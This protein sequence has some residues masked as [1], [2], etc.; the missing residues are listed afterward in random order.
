MDGRD[1]A[2]YRAACE[3]DGK[4]FDAHHGEPSDIFN[5]MIQSC[6]EQARCM[7]FR[8][9]SELFYLYMGHIGYNMKNIENYR[10]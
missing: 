9:Y 6:D 2:A 7:G 4:W 5:R 8:D 10:E 3:T 1:A